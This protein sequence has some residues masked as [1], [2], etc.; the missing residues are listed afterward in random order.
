MRNKS[1]LARTILAIICRVG[2]DFYPHLISVHQVALL[3]SDVAGGFVGATVGPFAR[4]DQNGNQRITFSS[5]I[6]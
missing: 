1:N 3:T 2:E 5:H 6:I 4:V